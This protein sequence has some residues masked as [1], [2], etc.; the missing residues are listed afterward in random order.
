MVSTSEDASGPSEEGFSRRA[1][2]SASSSSLSSNSAKASTAGAYDPLEENKH[3][4]KV[5]A[6]KPSFLPYRL[7]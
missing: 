2:A 5:V 6:H 4:V 1:V 7:R 3:G